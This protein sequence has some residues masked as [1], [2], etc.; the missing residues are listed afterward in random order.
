MRQGTLDAID[1]T[2]LKFLDLAAFLEDAGKHF[3]FPAGAIPVAQ[4][5]RKDPWE[6]DCMYSG[7]NMWKLS[8]SEEYV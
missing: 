5:D 8:N 6:S 4:F 3:D 1:P 2:R 7:E